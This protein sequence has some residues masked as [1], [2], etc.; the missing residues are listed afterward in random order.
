VA[1]SVAVLAALL[2]LPAWGSAAA[3]V[4]SVEAMIAAM[5]RL[6]PGLRTVVAD[7][8]ILLWVLGLRFTASATVYVKLPDRYKVVFHQVPWLFSRVQPAIVRLQTPRS[9]V[10]EYDI[11]RI[12]P[13]L[14]RGEL[15]YHLVGLP[16]VN[17]G[18]LLRAEVV[19]LASTWTIPQV[20][21]VYRWGTVVAEFAYDRVEGY[22]VP[23]ALNVRLAGMP[24]ALTSTYGNFRFNIDLPDHLFTTDLG[25]VGKC[26][27]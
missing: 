10:A 14:Y 16:K 23:V 26:A 4:P 18:D 3:P 15:A 1:G 20:T 21:L 2:A 6:N 8:E 11:T 24:V 19:V 17:P 5:E 27:G 9:F 7:Q 22:L 25:D 13:V 12:T